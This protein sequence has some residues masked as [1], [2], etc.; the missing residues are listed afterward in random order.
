MNEESKLSAEETFKSLSEILAENSTLPVGISSIRVTGAHHT[1]P[2]FIRKV[3]KTCLDTSKPAKSRSLLETLNAIQETTGNLMAF[4]VY[5]TANIKIDRASSSVSGD[6]DL[7][8]TIQVKEKPRLYVETGTDVGNV[9]GN[10]HANVLARNVFGGAELLS[11]NVSYGTRNRS[12][13][14]VNFETPVNADPK[15]RLRFNGHSNLRDN[16]SISSHDLLTKGITLSLQHQDLWSGEHLLSQ[17][18]LWRQVTHLT[19]YASPSVRLEAGDSLKQSL[20]YTYTRDTRDHLMIPTK[21][22]YVRQTLELAGFGFLPG[23]ASFLKSEFWGQK[24][25]ALNSSR[26]VSL[27][28]SARIGA[29]HSLNKKQVSLCDRFMLGGSTS[30]RGFS[31]DRIGPKDGRDS[32]GGTAYMAFSMSLLFPLPKVDASKP[33]RLQLFANAGG[34]SNLTSPNPCGTYK[35]ILSKPCI[36]TG[37]GLVYATPAARFELNFTLP[38]ATTEKDIGRKGLQFGAGIDFM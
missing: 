37:L 33:F 22:D 19:E 35:S 26:S 21:G 28:L 3:L 6:D 24:A 16:K 30:L 38:I 17:N 36:S 27:S 2:S 31:E 32:L 18:L 14:S 8:V 13:M 1:R 9:E 10:V 25:V 23:D 29:L 34:L 7:D 20:S 11:G 12:T 5:E 4:N 15:T